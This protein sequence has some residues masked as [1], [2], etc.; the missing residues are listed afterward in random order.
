MNFFQAFKARKTYIPLYK[1]KTY[2]TTAAWLKPLSAEEEEQLKGIEADRSVSVEGIMIWRNVADEMYA[3]E[4][5]KR[6]EQQPKEQKRKRLRRPHLDTR[7]LR[8]LAEETPVPPEFLPP[9]SLISVSG[10]C[11]P[12]GRSVCRRMTF[13][14]P[15][16]R[17]KPFW[18]AM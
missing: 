10:C 1:R 17:S 8:V 6:K 18:S 4:Q 13:S 7:V 12:S 2:S 3:K 14:K 15:S 5:S 9:G 16:A 11:R